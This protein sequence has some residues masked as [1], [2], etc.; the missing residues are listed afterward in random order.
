M[1]LYRPVGEKEKELIEESGVLR[2]METYKT[3]RSL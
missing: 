3:V 2:K 1:I